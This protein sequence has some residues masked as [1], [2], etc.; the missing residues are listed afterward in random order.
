MLRVFERLII[1]PTHHV[2]FPDVVAALTVLLRPEVSVSYGGVT[3]E[4][5][6]GKSTA[7]RDA[8]R[9]WRN[10]GSGVL[11]LS[12]RTGRVWHTH[13]SHGGVQ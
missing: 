11:F 12:K 3:G 9:R 13:G 2:D 5:G 10:Q 7:V 4:H 8:I 6:T 1:L